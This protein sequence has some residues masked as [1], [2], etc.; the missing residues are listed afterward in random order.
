MQ[1]KRAHQYRGDGGVIKRSRG[2]TALRELAEMRAT[3]PESQTNQ[4][5]TNGS[6]KEHCVAR[7]LLIQSTSCQTTS[8]R[9]TTT[10]I[11]LRPIPKRKLKKT[12][13]SPKA[14]SGLWP[15]ATSPIRLAISDS[16]NDNEAEN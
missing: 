11:S 14:T 1:K 6:L 8:F 4:L 2:E 9:F 3:T 10:T 13:S 16:D 15:S 7:L 12:A 5:N